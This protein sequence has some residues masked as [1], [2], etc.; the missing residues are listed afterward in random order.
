[1]TAMV[2]ACMQAVGALVLDTSFGRC[3]AFADR[4]VG[5]RSS[6]VRVFYPSSDPPSDGEEAASQRKAWIRLRA[7]AYARDVQSAARYADCAMWLVRMGRWEAFEH[8]RIVVASLLQD[9][10]PASVHGHAI[11]TADC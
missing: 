10:L 8:L 7:V 6:A 4:R 9:V 3:G 5:D 11:T 1:M 2:R